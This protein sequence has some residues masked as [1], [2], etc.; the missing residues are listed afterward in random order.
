MENAPAGSA[1]KD[2]PADV[3]QQGYAGLMDGKDHVV[4]GSAKNRLQAAGA[5]L[6]SGPQ[7][8]AAHAKAAKPEN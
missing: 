6:T 1:D 8:A 3:A 4:A 2:D 7:A 5:K